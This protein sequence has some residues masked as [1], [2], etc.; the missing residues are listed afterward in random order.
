MKWGSAWVHGMKWAD[1]LMKWGTSWHKYIMCKDLSILCTH[2]VSLSRAR[3]GGRQE[4]LTSGKV[5]WSGVRVHENR[6][7]LVVER[8]G[9]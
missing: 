3:R 4:D 2:E 7:L 1:A 5:A 8:G 6:T 9:G